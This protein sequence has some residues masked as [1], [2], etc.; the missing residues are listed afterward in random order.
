MFTLFCSACCRHFDVAKLPRDL[1]VRCNHCQA[2]VDARGNAI[3]APPVEK[4]PR[5]SQTLSNSAPRS[6]W[7]NSLIAGAVVG[8]LLAA[9]L[10]FDMSARGDASSPSPKG[11]TALERHKAF[12]FDAVRSQL[13]YP[14][15]A[16]FPSDETDYGM[17]Y[18]ADVDEIRL[19]SFVNYVSA[20]GDPVRSRWYVS[21]REAPTGELNLIDVSVYNPRSD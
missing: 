18:V 15:T 5:L 1:K 12:A 21:Y 2:P 13:P 20:G 9:V 11:Q 16:A 8:S 19:R 7:Q 17:E 14:D 10:L 4:P 3:K 6:Q